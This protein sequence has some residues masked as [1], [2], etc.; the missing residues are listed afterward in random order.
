LSF[1]LVIVLAGVARQ[2]SPANYSC[3]LETGGATLNLKVEM[4]NLKLAA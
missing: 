2:R 4:Q 3:H 1:C